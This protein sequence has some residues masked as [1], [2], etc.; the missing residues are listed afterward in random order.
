MFSLPCSWPHHHEVDIL[1]VAGSQVAVM[2]VGRGQYTSGRLTISGRIT[3]AQCFSLAPPESLKT[4]AVNLP[5][6]C[7]VLGSGATVHGCC[8]LRRR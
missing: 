6:F 4:T 1:E 7:E 8:S 5:F 2:V 3:P